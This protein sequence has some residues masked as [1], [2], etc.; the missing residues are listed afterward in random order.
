MLMTPK[1]LWMICRVS[2]K[3]HHCNFE[4][5]EKLTIVVHYM[6]LSASSF[7]VDELIPDGRK[8]KKSKVWNF[9]KLIE[10]GDERYS[11]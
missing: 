4:T 1:F 9:F 5:K 11:R 3:L 6:L 8:G 10:Y 2:H 7:V